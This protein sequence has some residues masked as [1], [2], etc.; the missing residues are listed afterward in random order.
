MGVLRATNL[1][2]TAQAFSMSD[3]EEA[4]KRVLLK[5]KLQAERLIDAAMKEA[6]QLKAQAR[7]EGARE[8]FEDGHAEGIQHGIEA[9][10]QQAFEKHSAELTALASTLA[11]VTTEFDARRQQIESELLREV[12][13]LATAVA[14]RV[15]KRH[16]L[17]EPAVLEANLAEAMKL[18]VGASDLRIAVHPSQRQLLEESLP[19]LKLQ[20][21]DLKHVDLAEDPSLAPGGCHVYTRSGCIDADLD[22][23]LNRVI[24]DLLPSTGNVGGSTGAEAP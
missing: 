10:R 23:Q 3:V 11:T 18:T 15:T 4:A 22:A 20:W 21:P 6:E 9:G 13:S 16:G 5:A 2:S 7:Q 19:R 17:I 1:P 24:G 8:G 12:V 14:T